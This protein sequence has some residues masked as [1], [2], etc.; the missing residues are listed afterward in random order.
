M[1]TGYNSRP[2]QRLYWSK[3]DDISCPLISKSMSRKTFEIIEK[4]IHFADN[5]NLPAGDKL[6]KVRPLRNRV[7]VSLQQFGVFAKDP[8]ID[9]QM[10]P[11][12][13]RHSAK[14]FI[15][16]KPVRYGYK[17]WVLASSDGY[18]YKFETYTGACDTKD[19]SKPLGLQVVS[20]FLS[21]V[22]NPAC[23]CVYFDNC[24]TSYYLLRD[25]C[26]K[27]FRAL[28]TIREGRTMK[29]PLRP[30]ISIEKE[31]LGF[32]DHRS[33][34]YMSIAQWKDNKVVYLGLNFSNIEPT[35]MVKRYSQREEKEISWV[36][37]F[38]FY[39]YNHGTG[40]VDQLDRFISKYRPKQS[41]KGVVLAAV[42]GLNRDANSGC[43][44]APCHRG[45]LSA[46]RFF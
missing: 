30:S 46:F 41:N 22:E 21:I 3:D 1:L 39:Q 12:F 26:Q 31:E 9:E 2:R 40:G 24:F 34:D 5:N 19:S 17:N 42:C 38:C 16:G 13:G 11:Y 27:N 18:P 6:A 23:H 8:A 28:G 44:E 37:P 45:K 33:D 29:Y 43:V 25:L 4:L 7:N 35:K 10:V 20:A 14:I 36:Q 15:R 32:F